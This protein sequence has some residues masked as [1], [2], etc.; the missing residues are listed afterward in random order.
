[1]SFRSAVH[2]FLICSL[3]AQV[4]LGGSAAQT[5]DN[6]ISGDVDVATRAC[7]PDRL[8]DNDSQATESLVTPGVFTRLTSYACDDDF[9]T[10]AVAE[11]EAVTATVTFEYAL[12][13]IDIALLAPTRR[14]D[15]Q[16]RS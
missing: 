5:D 11:D 9:Y 8:E 10:F 6:A 14:R 13:D 12:G 7:L 15:R 2:T 16:R 1:M 3:G 4:G